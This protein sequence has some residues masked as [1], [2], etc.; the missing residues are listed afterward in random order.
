VLVCHARSTSDQFSPAPC[1]CF[2]SG[3]F[4]SLTGAGTG[5]GAP[6]SHSPRPGFL[7]RV[8]PTRLKY[9]LH[10]HLPPVASSRPEHLHRVCQAPLTSPCQFR[11]PRPPGGRACLGSSGFTTVDEAA[12]ATMLLAPYAPDPNRPFLIQWHGS[13][14]TGSSARACPWAHP[15]V[16]CT[17]G[18]GPDQL[19]H[20]RP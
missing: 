14:D 10:L 12:P 19:A 1:P 4:P 16:A 13:T 11:R 3:C 18:A 7:T 5:L 17:P 2:G 15:S 9:L 20:L 8:T 6:D